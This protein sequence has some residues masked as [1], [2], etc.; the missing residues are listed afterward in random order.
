[1]N[2]VL[3]AALLGA[4]ILAIA[5]ALGCG[6]SDNSS[7]AA[8]TTTANAK[9]RKWKKLHWEWHATLAC[10]KG[11]EQADVVMHKAAG[12]PPPKPPSASPDWESFKVPVRALL[13]TFQQTLADLEAIKPDGED[14][15]DYERIL[16]RMRIELKEAE[17]NPN[18]PISSR[19]LKGS[20][21]T[22]YVY[23]IHA[24]LY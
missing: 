7:T 11:M 10:K 17:K 16:E 2:R 20:G 22:A 15:Y 3:K 24:C 9:G 18:A 13:P 1:M 4:A 23:G 6:S 12:E 19:P 14:A 21:K 8:E 5:A